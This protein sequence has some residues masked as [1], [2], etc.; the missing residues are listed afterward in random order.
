MSAINKIKKSL[1]RYAC[2]KSTQDYTFSFTLIPKQGQ[3]LGF[4][5]CDNKKK[6]L[7]SINYLHN[8]FILFW[9]FYQPQKLY[10]AN[11]LTQKLKM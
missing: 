9:N 11:D 8:D 3:V 6:K 1:L 7:F 5:C 10:L 2:N 4:T